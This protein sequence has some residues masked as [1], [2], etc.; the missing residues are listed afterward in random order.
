MNHIQPDP[1]YIRELHRT[2]G[3]LLNLVLILVLV[4]VCMPFLFLYGERITSWL[5]T[6][7]KNTMPSESALV[8]QS[9]SGNAAEPVSLYWSPSDISTISDS[10]LLKKVEYGKKL[11]Q[12]TA[13]YL[14]PKGS[15]AR[16]SNGMNCQNCHL[17][18]GTRVF[19]N[20]YGSVASTYPKFRARSGTTEDIY[21]R[22]NDCFERSLNGRPLDTLSEEM[23]AIKAYI[24][25]I[26]SN[27]PKGTKAEGSGLKELAF[28]DRAADPELGKK[29]YLAK[30]LSCHQAN[31]AGTLL[32]D[33]TEYVYPPLWGA[34]SYNDA[35]GL[36]RLSNFARYVKYNM[37]LGATHEN[38]QLTDEESW[39]VAAYINSQKRPHKKTPL[40]WPDVSKKPVDHPFGPYKDTYSQVQHKFGPFKPIQEFYKK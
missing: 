35:A 33:G 37:P 13:V 34:A 23:Q 16:I 39:D 22:V 11:I 10:G 15:V 29:V 32:A 28:L 12:H 21:K 1:R 30:C 31:G 19:G 3:R 20:N 6:S 26:G 24:E 36:F 2:I 38:P 40:D 14:G 5:K 7:S 8:R 25:F 17:D 27:V 9:P 4:I 18:A